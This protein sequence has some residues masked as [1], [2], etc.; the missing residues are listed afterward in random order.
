MVTKEKIDEAAAVYEAHMGPGLFNYDGEQHACGG[1]FVRQASVV[2]W[3][4]RC[5]D[6]YINSFFPPYEKP[7]YRVANKV[8]AKQ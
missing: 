7:P 1:N 6:S 2:T 5:S 4:P 8:T 3:D